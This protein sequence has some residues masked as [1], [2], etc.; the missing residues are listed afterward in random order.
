MTIPIQRT[1][2]AN[3]LAK[4]RQF[5]GIIQK[6][7]VKKTPINPKIAEHVSRILGKDASNYM[8]VSLKSDKN[9]SILVGMKDA[10]RDRWID[11][12]IAAAISAGVVASHY[13]RIVESD[14]GD[15]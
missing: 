15:L 10:N 1:V 3:E 12:A 5:I 6:T 8:R 11:P 7:G 4:F 14:A 9:K 13:G 2:P